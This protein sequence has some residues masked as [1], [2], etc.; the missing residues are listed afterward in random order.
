MLSCEVRDRFGPEAAPR[1]QPIPLSPAGITADWLTRVLG[2]AGARVST[3]AVLDH[4]AGTTTRLTLALTY[5]DAGSA[6]GLP[7]RVFVKCPTGLAQRLMLG[8]GGM[9]DGEPRFYA[10]VRPILEIE[11]PAL[12]F[13]SVDDRSWR[14][15]LVLEDVVHTRGAAF[16]RPGEQI[17]RD[18]IEDLLGTVAEWHGRL[19]ESPRLQ[20]WR[21]LRSPAEQLD[22]IDALLPLADR[23]SA[24]IRRAGALIPQAVRARRGDSAQP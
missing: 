5:N 16:W 2:D 24:G 15:I 1:E 18:Q 23:T 6:A 12:F 10:Q 17:T 4:T 19:W 14:S 13:G 20:A 7:E 8:L 22:V 11:T 21:W 3:V 9:I